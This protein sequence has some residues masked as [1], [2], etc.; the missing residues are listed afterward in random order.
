VW[1]RAKWPTGVKDGAGSRPISE[2][3][4][5]LGGVAGLSGERDQLY[6]TM[7][8]SFP[9]SIC[10]ND[11]GSVRPP[12]L[13]IWSKQVSEQSRLGA[14]HCGRRDFSLNRP[15]IFIQARFLSGG[16]K[17]TPFPYSNAFLRNCQ[18]K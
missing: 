8:L 2:G 17:H 9:L 13:A 16:D 4:I 12:G 18:A 11:A 6:A 3:Y 15:N 10:I 1:C 5:N 14:T 7:L